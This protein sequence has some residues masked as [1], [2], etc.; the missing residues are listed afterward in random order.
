M[1]TAA[2]WR[3][4]SASDTGLQR[5][6]NEDRVWLDEARGIFLV[7]DGLGGHAAG[8]TAAA[9]AVD[10]ISQHLRSPAQIKEVICA[11]NNEI[12]R[13][14]EQ[15]AEWRGMAC[16][17]TLAVIEDDQVFIGHVGDSRLYLLSQGKLKK[18]TFDHSPVGEQEDGGLLTEEQAMH[19][20]RRNEVFRDVGSAP[21]RIDDEL[22]IETRSFPFRE[23]A[24]LLLCSD[25]LS[26]CVTAAEMTAILDEY[27]GDA[28]RSAQRL[29]EAA[30]AAGGKDNISVVF[31]AGAGFTGKS[32]TSLGDARRRHATTRMRRDSAGFSK[33]A[34]YLLLLATGTAVGFGLWRGVLYFTAV[35]ATVKEPPVVAAVSHVIEVKA[36]DAHGIIDALATAASGDTISV[37]PGEFLGPLLLREGVDIRAKI[38]RQSILRCDPAASAEP[39]IGMI[40]RSVHK[41]EI[42]GLMIA[43]D[44]TH[45]MKDGVLLVDSSIELANM[46]ISGAAHS[47]IRIEGDSKPHLLENF[48]HNNG[49]AGV[50]IL[51]T[52][53]PVLV[54]NQILQNGLMVDAPRPG[55]EIGLAAKPVL[56]GNLISGNGADEPLKTGHAESKTSV[57]HQGEH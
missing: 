57:K 28:G 47:G 18:V 9:T 42:T 50:A 56:E 33:W 10:V 26:D 41:A 13:L 17:L 52:A 49:G 11:A 19:H 14:S 53:S 2:R 46:D 32:S 12:Y 37:P 35:P 15:H 8:E 25:G 6:I 27:D 31:V 40:A 22:F 34:K 44:A 45:P 51:N 55:I 23:D 43:A 30:N 21:R 20:P 16:V 3:A 54:H 7:V 48:I 24:A 1:K 29:V 5:T 38:P 4:G 39:G 36:T